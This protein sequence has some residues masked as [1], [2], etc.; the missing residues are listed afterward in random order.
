MS[1]ERRVPA[2]PATIPLSAPFLDGNEWA[3][4]KAC[5]DSGWVS[6]AG[7]FVE[8]FEAA[9]AER[10]QARF[11]VAAVNGTSALHVALVLSGVAPGDLVLVPSLTFIATAN[12]V[13]YT[14]AV[15]LFVDAEPEFWQIDVER[16]RRYL[17]D[18]CEQGPVGTRDRASG[19]RVAAILPVDVLG[20]PAD[21]APLAEL[22]SRFGLHL[23]QDSAEALGA[24]YRGEPVGRRADVAA[25]SFNGNKIVT[26][27][28]GG[29]IVTDR[30][31]WAA[32]ARHLTTQA[33]AHPFE[34][35]HDEVGFN[36]RLTNLQ[37][38]LGCAQLEQLDARIEARRRIAERY[39]SALATLPGVT[40]MPE[41]E[42]ARSTFWLYTATFRPER[43]APASRDLLRHLAEAGIQTRPLW[44]PLHR[45][46]PFAGSRCLGGAV[47][48]DLY[49]TALSLP[50]SASLSV[51]DQGRVI[52]VLGGLFDRSG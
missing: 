50:S 49:A 38:A 11:A 44:Q 40:V 41:A 9:V 51:A 39:R 13:R 30:E 21:A 7:P 5:L 35:Q 31:D 47:A 52:E 43:G 8:R 22:A 42:W 18:E 37:A 15:P 6:S 33:R 2:G 34:Y 27:G 23:V 46:P 19:R 1:S 48:E 26:A 12:A 36:Y 25:L 29:M 10:L 20:H 4:V 32:R 16:V 28:G 3:Y 45:S 14:G 17:E 24:L